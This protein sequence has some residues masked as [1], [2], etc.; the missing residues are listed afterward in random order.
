MQNNLLIK[1]IYVIFIFLIVLY[2]FYNIYL[3]INTPLTTGQLNVNSNK[4]GS[5]LTISQPN[6]QAQVI[7]LGSANI[8]LKPGKYLVAAYYQ[9][10]LN[11][12]ITTILKQRLVSITVNPDNGVVLPTV[13][14]ILFSGTS[15]L[16]AHGLTTSQV[17]QLKDLFFIFN[18]NAKSVFVVTNSFQSGPI[19]FLSPLFTASFNVIVDNT[20]YTAD[21]TYGAFRNIQL[22]LINQQT[23]KIVY[24][25]PTI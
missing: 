8:R 23:N 12:H 10:K 19:N 9:G 3:V 15:T 22:T 16:I 25:S 1:R 14:N 2:S 24:S 7:G 17:N 18:K 4:S 20:N 13:N 11:M 5:I 21:I 6:H